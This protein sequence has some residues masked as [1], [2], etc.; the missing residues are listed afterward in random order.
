MYIKAY[1]EEIFMNL[2]GIYNKSLNKKQIAL[3]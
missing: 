2:I 3:E 1:E